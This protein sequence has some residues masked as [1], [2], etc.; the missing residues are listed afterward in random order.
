MAALQRSE[1]LYDQIYEIFWSKIVSGEITPRQRLSDVEWSKRLEVSRTPVR[2]ALRKL[3]QD[4]VLE[5]LARGGYEVRSVRVLDLRCLYN[6]RA[7]LEALAMR[8]AA[9]RITAKEGKALARLIDETEQL[10]ARNDFETALHRNTQFHD[11]VVALSENGYLQHLLLGIRRLILFSRSALMNAARSHPEA[12]RA[13]ALHLIATQK[14]HRLILE[15]LLARDGE[16]AAA[17]M[18]RHLF[19]TADDMERLFEEGVRERV[20]V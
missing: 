3:E 2:E 11:Q 4:G 7:A 18:Q 14:D 12:Q 17:A 8:D 5:P 1:H 20:S 16:G 6:C 9:A 19:G 10:I 13:Y 15:R